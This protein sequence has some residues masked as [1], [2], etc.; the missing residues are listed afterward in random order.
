[1]PSP[2]QFSVVVKVNPEVAT[3]AASRAQLNRCGAHPS[4][5]R[6]RIV[7]QSDGSRN[8][9]DVAGLIRTPHIN[10]LVAGFR[11]VIGHRI[12]GRAPIVPRL[13][14][15]LYEIAICS[16]G[17]AISSIGT[18]RSSKPDQALAQTVE[19]I[20]SRRGWQWLAL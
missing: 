6:R 7:S 3:V 1:M 19:I 17:I 5:G 11:T 12:G 8:G 10:R 9:R 20:G 13:G 15:L 16:T 2:V 14:H 18:Y 4:D